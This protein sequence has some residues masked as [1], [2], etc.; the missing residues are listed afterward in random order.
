LAEWCKTA[1]RACGPFFADEGE[2]QYEFSFVDGMLLRVD[3][4]TGRTP[5]YGDRG[6]E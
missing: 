2:S 4:S 6:K 1:V 5:F 3:L